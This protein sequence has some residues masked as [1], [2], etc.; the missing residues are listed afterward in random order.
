MPLSLSD[1]N[2]SNAAVHYELPHIILP[3]FATHADA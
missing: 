1:Q 2:K 3:V